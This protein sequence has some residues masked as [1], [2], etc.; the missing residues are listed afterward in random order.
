M[1]YEDLKILDE[2]RQKGSITEE[3]YQKEKQ[4]IFDRTENVSLSSALFGMSENSYLALIHVSQLG[5]YLLPLLGFFFPFILWIMNKDNN[6]KVDS[7]GKDVINFVLSWLIYS[8][9]AVILCIILIGIPILIALAVLQFVFAILA[10]I[11][12]VNGESWKYP[13]TITILK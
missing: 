6:S 8:V 3:E 13:M 10:T 2:L 4:K 9:G 1:N 11:K 5:G 12:T 7:T